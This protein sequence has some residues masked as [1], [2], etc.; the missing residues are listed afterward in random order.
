MPERLNAENGI[1]DR[2]YL[3]PTEMRAWQVGSPEPAPQWSR[4]AFATGKIIHTGF[5]FGV[6]TQGGITTARAGDWI[7]KDPCGRLYVFPDDEF[8]EGFAP[9]AA[10]TP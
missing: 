3:K 7:V 2:Y 6:E 1:E 4:D 5:V 10:Q 8:R 9:V